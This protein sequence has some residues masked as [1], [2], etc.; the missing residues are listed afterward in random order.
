MKKITL[1]LV[2]AVFATKSFAHCP[3]PQWCPK[4]D[5]HQTLWTGEPIDAIEFPTV[6]GKTLVVEGVDMTAKKMN[7]RHF[8]AAT[9]DSTSE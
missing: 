6:M 9:T 1:I 8:I 7:I 4:A 3:I 5:L 2:F